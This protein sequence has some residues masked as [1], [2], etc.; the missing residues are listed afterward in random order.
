VRAPEANGDGGLE[1]L[2]EHVADDAARTAAQARAEARRAAE[3][4]LAEAEQAARRIEAGAEAA[5]AAEGQRE[6]RRRIALAEIEAR[7]TLLARREEQLERALEQAAARLCGRLE[8]DGALVAAW[9]RAAARA[10]GERAP[11]VRIAKGMQARVEPL[12]G[13]GLEP[14]WEELPDAGPGAVVAS[15][16]GRREVDATLAGVVARQREAARA[17]AAAALFEGEE[18]EP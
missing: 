1:A 18:P 8:A 16:D 11:R 17:R 10:L 2:L 13:D 14:V 3:Q 9:I 4:R 5:G 15:G 6:A 7:K 12:L